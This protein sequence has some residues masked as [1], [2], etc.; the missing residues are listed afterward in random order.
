MGVFSVWSFLLA[1]RRGRVAGETFSARIVPRGLMQEKYTGLIADPAVSLAVGVGSAGTGKTLLA[2]QGFSDLYKQGLARRLILTRPL[3]SVG[4][5]DLGFLPGSV[6]QKMDPWLAP[7]VDCL[8]EFWSAG[9]VREMFTQG[10][11]SVV[12]LG[13]MR[14]RT[15]GGGVFILADEMQNSSPEQM[16]M[17]L[18]RLGEG[19]KIVITGDLMQSDLR[20]VNGLGDLI[21]RLDACPIPGVGVVRFGQGNV[22]RSSFVRDVIQM[23]EGDGGPVW[24]DLP[25]F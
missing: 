3:V 19:G 10:V 5:E 25:H 2:C 18:T 15:F 21:R 11:I 9:T 23:Y 13:F 16:K 14:G 12:P 20:G 6:H 1:S 17:M 22:C 8:G 24:N 4:G 7:V